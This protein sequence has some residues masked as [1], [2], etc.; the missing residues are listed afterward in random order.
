MLFGPLSSKGHQSVQRLACK[1]CTE[2]WS[3]SYRDH[4][5]ILGL[6]TTCDHR[7]FLKLCTMFKIVN[8]TF[9]FPESIINLRTRFQTNSMSTRHVST[10][11]LYIP[12][13]QFMEWPSNDYYNTSLSSLVVLRTTYVDSCFCR[14]TTISIVSCLVCI[15][16]KK[17]IK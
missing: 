3:A 17:Y 12:Y 14:N 15:K 6:P 9:S 1:I 10:N 2:D 5:Y 7:I 16:K 13:A 8:N 11:S 4:L